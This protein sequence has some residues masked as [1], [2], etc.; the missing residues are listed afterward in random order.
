[1]MKSLS[2]NMAKYSVF[3]PAKPICMARPSLE[4]IRTIRMAAHKLEVSANY[5]WGH[6]GSCN[7][8]FLA[9][10][11]TRLTKEEIHRRAMMRYGD[12][13]EQLTD[14]C[15]TSGLPIDETISELIS[16]GF[17]SEDLKNLEKLSD[18]WILRS[19][20]PAER[21]L[22]F[23]VRLDVVKYLRTWAD[24]LE[25]TLLTNVTLPEIG[26]TALNLV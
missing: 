7:C 13:S 15:P 16:F 8:G 22:H 5:Q 2:I 26:K 20:P 19:L 25:E 9:Q 4:L 11:V 6:M 14:Y 12:W 18:P 17:D 24:L 10:E 23:N 21:N 3:S 1:M